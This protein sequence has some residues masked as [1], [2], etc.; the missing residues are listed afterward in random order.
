MRKLTIGVMALLASS[1]LASGAPAW[2]QDS[3]GAP[4]EQTHFKVSTYKPAVHDAATTKGLARFNHDRY[5]MFIH[6]GI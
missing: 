1:A 6:W 4:P 3:V 2:A 5:S